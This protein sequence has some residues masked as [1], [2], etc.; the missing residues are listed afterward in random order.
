MRQTLSITVSPNFHS[1][2]ST[3]TLTSSKAKESVV[4]P[5]TLSKCVYTYRHHALY[6]KTASATADSFD[7]MSP[8]YYNRHHHHRHQQIVYNNDSISST[9]AKQDHKH[10]WSEQAS[11]PKECHTAASTE[12][13]HRTMNESLSTQNH[14]SAEICAL[15]G[16][17]P[18]SIHGHAASTATPHFSFFLRVQFFIIIV[19]SC[20]FRSI[21]GSS[22]SHSRPERSN[23]TE[24]EALH[25]TCGGWSRKSAC[26]HMFTR[27]GLVACFY[28]RIGPPSTPLR[29]PTMR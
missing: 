3:S 22:S 16:K 10:W 13:N 24:E 5:M 21:R 20:Y 26:V 12:T 29:E 19:I 15:T 8:W 14:E 1:S 17:V 27:R 6:R 2:I 7:W 11:K 23:C 4:G 9:T 28:S 18:W 25:V